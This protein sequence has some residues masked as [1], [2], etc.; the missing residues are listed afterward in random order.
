VVVT[1]QSYQNVDANGLNYDK[2]T[3]DE[4]R[5][6]LTKIED[7]ID[8]SL[9]HNK[10]YKGQKV[11]NHT[12]NLSINDSRQK[13]PTLSGIQNA[14]GPGSRQGSQNLRSSKEEPKNERSMKHSLTQMEDLTIKS[15]KNLYKMRPRLFLHRD[16]TLSNLMTLDDADPIDRA[17]VRIKKNIKAS[18]PKA[19]V[20]TSVGKRGRKTR[21]GQDGR[22]DSDQVD[23]ADS[24]DK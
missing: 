5:Q 21:D 6:S 17:R 7:R 12:R 9:L 24:K 18:I 13:S 2:S 3:L 20:N 8:F 19:L 22:T 11:R 16:V 4:Q 15:R 23:T 14:G 1:I 10:K